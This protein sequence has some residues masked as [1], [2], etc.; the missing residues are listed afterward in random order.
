M[1]GTML[2]GEANS[3]VKVI[4]AETRPYFQ[5]SRL[6]ASCVAD[7]GFDVTVISDNMPAYVM[8]KRKVDIYT[9]ASDVISMDGYV[10]IK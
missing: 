2:R 3:A 5:G 8:H 9:S 4:C 6:T 1:V 7:M 10:G